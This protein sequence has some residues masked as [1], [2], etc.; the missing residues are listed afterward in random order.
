MMNSIT[1]HTTKRQELSVKTQAMA[2]VLALMAAVALPQLFHVMGRVSGLGTAFGE[3]L[4]PMHLPIILVGLLAG[5][6]AGGLAGLLAPVIS[7]ALTGM[8]G[9]LCCHL[10]YLNLVFTD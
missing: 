6:Y 10:W 7:F 5:T 2:T 4:L 9:V 1:V 3:T 8:P